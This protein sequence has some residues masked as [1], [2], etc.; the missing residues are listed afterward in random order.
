[1]AF[2]DFGLDLPLPELSSFRLIGAWLFARLG[3]RHLIAFDLDQK[4]V[5]WVLGADGHLGFRPIAFPEAPRFGPTFGTTAQYLLV[6]LSTGRR[7]LIHAESGKLLEALEADT[8]TA[9]VWW[10]QVPEETDGKVIVS[11]GPG[12]IRL[13]NP[14]T[15]VVKWT[16]RAIGEASLTG[17][18][19]QVK[20]YCDPLLISVRRNHGVELTGLDPA[21]G[22]RFGK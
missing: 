3:P 7:W 22:N 1:M 9:K 2:L 8:R 13:L 4:R 5:A 6:Q 16:H 10:Q 15:G 21:N 18:P 11:D 19:P 12:L 14:A 20:F 17:E